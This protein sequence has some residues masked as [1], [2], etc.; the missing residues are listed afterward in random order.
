MCAHLQS[1]FAG[2]SGTALELSTAFS[3]SVWK[4]DLYI[5]TSPVP[6]L[7]LEPH[8]SGRVVLAVAFFHCVGCTAI[9]LYCC[10]AVLLFVDGVEGAEKRCSLAA[11]PVTLT[12]C[13]IV[14]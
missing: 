5:T 13:T 7:S 8:G 10:W 12:H 11:L 9:G 2:L 6:W 4:C 14:G 3:D 1:H